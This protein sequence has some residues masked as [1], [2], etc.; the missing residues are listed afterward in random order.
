M[1]L[2]QSILTLQMTLTEIGTS[3]K[4]DGVSSCTAGFAKAAPQKDAVMRAIV[5][6]FMVVDYFVWLKVGDAMIWM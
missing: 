4:V 1:R 3:V 2:D 6:N 5:V